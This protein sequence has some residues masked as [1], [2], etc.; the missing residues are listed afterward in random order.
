MQL[1]NHFWILGGTTNCE[2]GN[3]QILEIY[4]NLRLILAILVFIIHYKLQNSFIEP[5]NQRSYSE[6]LAVLSKH[7]KIWS[8]KKKNWIDGPKIPLEYAFLDTFA[9]PISRTKILFVGVASTS[10][11][12]FIKH[13]NSNY[14]GE[15]IYVKDFPILKDKVLL[16]NFGT[17]AWTELSSIPITGNSWMNKISCSIFFNG[18]GYVQRS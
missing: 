10:T 4:Q 1:G 7:S 5:Q 3:C 12:N 2:P 15:D 13:E 17:K 11:D 14:N 16:Y 6:P 8:M 9:I 18:K